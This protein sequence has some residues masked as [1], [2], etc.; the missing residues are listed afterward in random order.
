[1]QVSLTPGSN[2][3]GATCSRPTHTYAVCIA[4]PAVPGRQPSTKHAPGAATCSHGALLGLSR[5]L[6]AP[7]S[8]PPP[9][10]TQAC[11]THSLKRMQQAA[12]SST[13]ERQQHSSMSGRSSHMSGSAAC[14]AGRSS[15]THD[16]PQPTCVSRYSSVRG[17]S[18]TLLAPAQMTA[19]GVLPSSVRS[20]LTSM[21]LSPPRCTPPMP[22][23]QQERMGL[24]SGAASKMLHAQQL[25][26]SWCGAQL[27]QA[28]V[29]GSSAR[30]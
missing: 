9:S 12:S 19:T 18:S 26:R 29:P 22:P 15:H 25:V 3:Q 21:E 11:S 5:T 13:P 10:R 7:P 17:M 4:S 2:L 20:A 30:Q 28:V 1:M 27:C 8:H 14:Q 6:R 16:M 23:A 24:L